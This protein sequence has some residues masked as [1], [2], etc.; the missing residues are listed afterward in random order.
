MTKK[1]NQ[2]LLD[3]LTEQ[4]KRNSTKV[5]CVSEVR[6]NDDGSAIES[7]EGLYSDEVK[8]LKKA[9]HINQQNREDNRGEYG[10]S[11][12]FAVV[13]EHSLDD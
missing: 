5:Y 11:S 3:E 12:S 7:V 4:E 9:N 1:N 8:A 2:K 13:D 6:M 10:N